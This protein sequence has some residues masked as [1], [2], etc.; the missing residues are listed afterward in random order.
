MTNRLVRVWRARISSLKGLSVAPV[1]VKRHR[2]SLNLNGCS[3]Q[4]YV[5]GLFVGAGPYHHGLFEDNE[6]F[7]AGVT[8]NPRT[9]RNQTGYLFV[10]DRGGT[11]CQGRASVGLGCA[12]LGRPW[13]QPPLLRLLVFLAV[14]IFGRILLRLV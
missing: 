10:T 14:G 8:V 3:Q 12:F 2:C 9:M 11:G 13:G 4:S 7:P 1:P 6:Y 5:E